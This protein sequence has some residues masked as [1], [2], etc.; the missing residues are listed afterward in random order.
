MAEGEDS[1]QYF[2]RWARRQYLTKHEQQRRTR[3]KAEGARRIDVTL[4]GQMLEDFER[5]K[6]WLDGVNRIGIER[7]I[8]NRP[9]TM[10]DG[11][12]VTIPPPRLSDTE[13][14]KSAL[15]LAA[16]HLDDEERG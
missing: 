4:R 5:V 15:S 14:I 2:R 1:I 9:K 12:T 8:Y 7:G 13:I 6:Q 10:P 16:A 3:A 11:R